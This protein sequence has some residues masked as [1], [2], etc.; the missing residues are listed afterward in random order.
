MR[1][2][3]VP[4]LAVGLAATPSATALADPVPPEQQ[5]Q[6]TYAQAFVGGGTDLVGL[7]LAFDHEPPAGTVIATTVSS[8]GRP[9]A[10]HS[11]T[12]GADDATGSLI[13]LGAGADTA[14]YI[15]VSYRPLDDIAYSYQPRYT[16]ADFAGTSL[17]YA[18]TVTHPGADAYSSSGSVPV[19]LEEP[20]TC[21]DAAQE[22]SR[23]LPVQ[24]WSEKTG[25]PKAGRKLT[26]TPTIAPG[27]K[28]RYLWKVTYKGKYRAVGHRRALRV[29]KEWLKGQYYVHLLVTVRK[30]GKL[31]AREGIE[32]M[33]KLH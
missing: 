23:L 29:K 31:T 9:I 8:C 30:K 24:Q 19:E 16:P 1:L 4:L 11:R 10:E 26:V 3:L 5:A 33:P 20:R 7:G 14:P 6:V 12:A 21:A 28:V 15:P 17:E 27:A 2:L 18:V 32:F 13:D 22:W 25:K